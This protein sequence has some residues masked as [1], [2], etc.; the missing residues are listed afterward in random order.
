MARSIQEQTAEALTDPDRIPRP[1][2][3][4]A[5]PWGHEAIFAETPHYA[6]KIFYITAGK[7][8]SLQLH[9]HKHESLYLICGRLQISV[10]SSPDEL[11]VFDILPGQAITFPPQTVHRILALTDAEIFEASTPEME[12]VVRL[13]DDY[14]RAGT[15]DP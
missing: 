8:I 14:G 3:I 4:V 5:K 1:P 15:S 9:K 2:R 10:G 7:R 6:A 13:E 12:D 11:Q